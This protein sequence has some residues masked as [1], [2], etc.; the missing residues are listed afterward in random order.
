M[1]KPLTNLFNI[2]KDKKLSSSKNI[3]ED[4]VSEK[5]KS[6]IIFGFIISIS[7]ILLLLF[8]INNKFGWSKKIT[9]SLKKII[10]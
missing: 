9:Q 10:N 5:S 1:N 3:P 2:K 8:T 7:S 4:K 6:L